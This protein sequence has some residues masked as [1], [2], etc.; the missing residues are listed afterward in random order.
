MAAGELAAAVQQ[1]VADAVDNLIRVG[2]VT[3]IPAPKVTVTI[4]G[5]GSVTLPRNAAYTPTV[6]DTVQILCAR[7][8]GWFILCKIA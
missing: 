7:R 2:T 6:G 4:A 3:A 8:G 5:G 1:A